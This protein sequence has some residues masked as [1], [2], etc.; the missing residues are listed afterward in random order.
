MKGNEKISVEI[1]RPALNGG[2][3]VTEKWT[4]ERDNTTESLGEMLV[5]VDKMLKCLGYCY[6]GKLDIVE[7]EI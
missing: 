1:T 3:D 2:F 7:E 6:D 4:Y 5:I